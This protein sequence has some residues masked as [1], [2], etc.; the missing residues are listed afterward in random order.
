MDY[1]RLGYRFVWALHAADLTLT[2]APAQAAPAVFKDRT[3]ELGLAPAGDGVCWADFNHDG[4]VDLGA[5]GAIWLNHA[6][7]NFAKI[8]E[9]GAGVA[10]DFNND[11]FTDF[12]SWS[13]LKLYRNDGGTGFV[14]FKLPELPKCVSR[15]AAWG[16]FNGD[17]FTDLYVGGYEDWDAG[18]T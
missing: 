1:H 15:G 10:A 8:A 12:F 2:V 13:R 14:E 7:T 5:G 16:D 17:G 9:V 11:G 18:I 4:W 6:G 3:A